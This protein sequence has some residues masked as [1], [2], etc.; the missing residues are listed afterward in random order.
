MAFL[1]VMS[2]TAVKLMVNRDKTEEEAVEIELGT[3][4]SYERMGLV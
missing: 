2:L 4:F 1:I 3:N